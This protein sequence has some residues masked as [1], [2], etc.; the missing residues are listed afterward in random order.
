MSKSIARALTRPRLFDASSTHDP[1]TDCGPSPLPGAA[2]PG[3]RSLVAAAGA[4]VA[5]LLATFA[6]AAPA[7]AAPLS[8]ADQA[9]VDSTVQQAVTANG[10]G[11]ITIK[12]SGP[13]GD[14]EKAYGDRSSAPKVPMALGDSF[15]IGSITKTF[16]A[17]AILKQVELGNLSLNDKLDQF[18]TGIPNGNL[19][20]VK[21]LLAMQSGVYDYQQDAG[22]RLQV[23]LTPWAAFEPE[24]ILTILRNPSHQPLF[25]PG[26]KTEYS[27]SNY[28][29]LGF[30]LEAVTGQDAETVI[31]N[32]VI[33]PLGLTNTKFPTA[34]NTNPIYSMPSPYA[35]GYAKDYLIPG[36]TQDV[37]AFN[38]N[39]LWTAGA[40]IS[41]VGD[42]EKYVKALGQGQLLNASTNA[43]R[44]QFC[45][46]PYAYEGP[47]QWGYGLGLASFG[48][49]IGHPGA[50]SG[51]N[52]VAFYEPTS[53]AAIAGLENY[54]T[55]AAPARVWTQVFTRIAEH[56][57]P[58]S[59]AT[60]SYPTC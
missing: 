6:L 59:T 45:P 20:T 50:M 38:P 39:L 48:S 26:A 40:I 8:A 27:E 2:A 31:T 21:Q 35:T 19:I 60:P 5:A 33:T 34:A 42:V 54:T 44:K 46:M 25:A 32:D 52:S 22:L 4:S 16:T 12:I 24:Q 30:I 41:N 36:T 14:Y 47:T 3:R 51:Y 15:R 1:A 23:G 11:G 55:A 13:K 53:G 58:G 7:Q 17:T 43:L 28:V 18:V 49:W 56:L 37:T 10:T 57:Y 9:F 29:L